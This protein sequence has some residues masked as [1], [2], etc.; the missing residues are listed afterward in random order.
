[1]RVGCRSSPELLVSRLPSGRHTVAALEPAL[2][3]EIIDR[4]RL[5]V[6]FFRGARLVYRN[7]A[8]DK[9][10]ERLS[11]S[12]GIEVKVLLQDH[13]RRLEPGDEG[14]PEAVS[15][16]FS[17]AGEPFSVHVL[18]V[19]GDGPSGSVRGSLVT[20]RET[21]TDREA[22]TR[23]YALSARQWQV[24]ELVLRGYSNREVATAL[25]VTLATTKKHLTRIFDKVGVDSRAQL[26]S[27]LV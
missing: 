9:L 16:L 2:A 13:L 11:R 5:A 25:G 17:P 22:F 19:E 15:L 14:A 26:M 7:R 8:A 21:G 23:R 27:R 6:F 10:A 1:M 12:H 24:V 20:L 3:G 18:T 4:L